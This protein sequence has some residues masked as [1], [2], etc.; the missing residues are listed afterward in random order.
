M[1][2]SAFKSANINQTNQM[3]QGIN[4][5][6]SGVKDAAVLVAGALSF[7]GIA[8]GES[9]LNDALQHTFAG[10]VGGIGGNIML[11]SMQEKREL[12]KEETKT[13]AEFFETQYGKVPKDSE[14]GLK[15]QEQLD[16]EG[17]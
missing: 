12:K 5:I 9:L 17:V 15:I 16:K 7:S 3:T 4:T 11:M 13:P 2:S 6:T 14:L 8:G 1:I 10:K